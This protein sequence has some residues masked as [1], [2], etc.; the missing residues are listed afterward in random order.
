MTPYV[1]P[2]KVFVDLYGKGL[3]YRGRRT[4]IGTAAQTAIWMKR[5][6]INR[7][8]E[9]FTTC[10]MKSWKSLVDSLK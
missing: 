4:S 10:G 8:R 7:R 6:S 1:A 2:W 9:I 3:I 5:S